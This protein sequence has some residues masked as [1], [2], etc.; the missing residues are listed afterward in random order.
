M[1]MILVM[2]DDNGNDAGDAHVD[3]DNAMGDICNDDI[4]TIR[5]D[6]SDL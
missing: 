3:E 2:V 6:N 1:V 5:A 4:C